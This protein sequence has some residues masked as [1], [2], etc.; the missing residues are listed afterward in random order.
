M[1]PSRALLAW[2]EQTVGSV[3]LAC[4]R[5]TGGITSNVHLVTIGDAA[6]VLRSWDEPMPEWARGAVPRE[7]AILGALAITG[8]PVPRLVAAIDELPGPALLMTRVPGGVELMPR[9]R[10]AWLREMAAMLAR[11]HAADVD[12]PPFESWVDA[13]QLAPPAD[14]QRP[15][16]WREAFA[17]LATPAPAER[18]FIH[19]DYQH[20]NLLWTG[21]Q[22]TGVVDW[23]YASA[24]PPSV[25]VGH[26]R[27][28][29][30]LLFS[31][32]IAEQFRELYEAASGRRVDPWWDVH[33]LMS[34]GPDWKHFLP[35]QI[36]GRAP[37]DVDGML[38]RLERLLEATLRRV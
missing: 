21:E 33:A 1:P 15:E 10:D 36:D 24:G 23:T 5:L 20:F 12:A 29:L 16:L 11:I 35:L 6:Y 32:E 25:D 4:E 17:L 18:T 22:L 34:F 13:G 8:L 3:V 27:L 30:A 9:D 7:A 19:R 31:A 2:V 38:A 28:N 26:C 37:L 14:S